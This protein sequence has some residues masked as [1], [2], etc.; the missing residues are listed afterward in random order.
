[1][2]PGLSKT[3]DAQGVIPR[4]CIVKAGSS[5]CTVTVAA[6]ATDALLGVSGVVGAADA[7]PIE[8]IHSGIADVKIGGFVSYGD[9]I[10]SDANGYGVKAN[11]SSGQTCEAIGKA[12]ESGNS[13]DIVRVLITLTQVKG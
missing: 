9:W 6:A 8:V 12:L 1:M 2:N 5:E 3:Y 10:A 4:N 11:P 7:M 13:G